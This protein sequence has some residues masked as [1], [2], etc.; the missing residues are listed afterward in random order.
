MYVY[1][2][3]RAK[4]HKMCFAQQTLFSTMNKRM[5]NDSEDKKRK[6]S[7]LVVLWRRYRIITNF[8]SLWFWYC[9]WLSHSFNY[10][11]YHYYC[12]HIKLISIT[13]ISTKQR[14]QIVIL[15]QL[16]VAQK[17]SIPE[18]WWW[19]NFHVSCLHFVYPFLVNIY[20]IKLWKIDQSDGKLW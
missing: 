11:L 10:R 19:W 1:A 4:W 14:Q 5:R 2:F 15:V 6:K 16:I 18:S 12:W 9:P 7:K 13:D 17:Q 20:G 8:L 3:I